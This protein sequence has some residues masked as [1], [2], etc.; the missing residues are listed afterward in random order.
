MQIHAM[1]TI[2][3][4]E[5]P[6][7]CVEDGKRTC[8]LLEH[9]NQSVLQHIVDW[10]A[11]TGVKYI[12]ECP[13]SIVRGQQLAELEREQNFEKYRDPQYRKQIN[14]LKGEFCPKG[15]SAL[16]TAKDEKGIPVFQRGYAGTLGGKPI[17]H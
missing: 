5:I 3:A 6:P 7:L 8:F 13:Y 2:G 1:Y 12:S 15:G 10:I 9:P 11:Y 17:Q 4:V 14:A 16:Y